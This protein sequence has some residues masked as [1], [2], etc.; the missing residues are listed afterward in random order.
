MIMNDNDNNDS[1][2]NNDN[3]TETLNNIV[4]CGKYLFNGF[5][6]YIGKYLNYSFFNWFR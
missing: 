2:S 3:V 4:T 5:S 1:N 6:Y